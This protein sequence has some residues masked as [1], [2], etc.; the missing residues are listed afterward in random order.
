MHGGLVSSA[1]AAA[2]NLV[3]GPF[4]DLD[5][6]MTELLDT[7]MCES[8]ETEMTSRSESGVATGLDLMVPDLR[9]SEDGGSFVRADV[10]ESPAGLRAK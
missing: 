8:E 3:L 9:G 1:D 6:K 2:R 7:D 10:G 4:D 5:T